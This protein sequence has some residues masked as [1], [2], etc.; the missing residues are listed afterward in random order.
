MG[1]SWPLGLIVPVQDPTPFSPFLPQGWQD[2]LARTAGA[3]YE[4]VELAITDPTS[5]DSTR[6][7]ADLRRAGLRLSSITT[8]QAAAKEGLSLSSPDDHVRRRAVER[9]HAHA[10]FAAPFDAVVIVGLLR[11]TDGDQALLVESLRECARSAPRVRLAVEPLNRYDSRLLNTVAEALAV[12]DAVG[13]ENVGLLFDTFHANIEEP[14][15]G[16]AIRAA[17][18]RLAHVH[19]ADSNRWPPGHGHLDFRAVW[20]ALDDIGYGGNLVL[21]CFPKP[22]AEAVLTAAD[23]IRSW[24]RGVR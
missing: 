5:V 10:R 13:A 11:G 7:A 1:R 22:D 23:R 4:V 17:G 16:E 24:W 20:D 14:E 9:I 8:G 15:I 12:V 18:D 2:A 3:G 6:V 19:L 21:E